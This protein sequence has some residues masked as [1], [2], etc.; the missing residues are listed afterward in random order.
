M[1]RKTLT[2]A[3]PLL[4]I[5][6]IPVLLRDTA[7]LNPSGTDQLVIVT[8]HNEAIR[9]EFERAF[10]RFAKTR[11]GRDIDI[12]WRTPG[13]TSEIVRY[14]RSAY[15]ANFRHWWTSQGKP[16][17]AT[18]Q[19]A[20]LDRKLT[21]AS[22][23][24]NAWAARQA[25][26][27]SDVSIGVDLLFGG[28]EFDARSLASEGILVPCGFRTRHPDLFTGDEPCLTR[29]VSGETWYD[30]DDRYY[31]TCLA[32]FG[33]CYNMD[34][35][36]EI[37]PG[38]ATPTQWNDLGEPWFLGQIGVADPSK[39]GSI[40]KCFE[41]LI[42]QQMARTARTCQAGTEAVPLGK[43]TEGLDRGW[44]NAM[45]LIRRISANAR[46]FTFAAGR[47]PVDV[48]QGD[49]AAG[50]C[51][52]FYGRAQAE[53]AQAETDRE[54]MRYITPPGGSSISADPIALFRG[55]PHAEA[56]KAFIDFVLSRE[57]QQ[58]WNYRPGTP[59]G[60][61][62]YALR[63]LPIRRDLYTPADKAN[64]SDPNAEPFVLAGQ[65][66]YQ[67]PWTGR[68]F[69]LIRVLIRVMAI[70]CHP[71]LRE[72]WQ[73]IIA[74]GGPERLPDAM[75]SLGKLPFAHHEAEAVAAE[76]RDPKK[77]ILLTRAWAEFFRAAYV[78]ARDLAANGPLTATQQ[79]DAATPDRRDQRL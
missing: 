78:D 37:H 33:I 26:L 19:A 44:H 59:G 3:A 20:F 46:Y 53:W 79:A 70:D 73:A 23:P 58:L 45:L 7:V 64:M 65:F 15:T 66:A 32:A 16:W 57:G 40:N 13:G 76:L 42:Q 30:T 52:D 35:L 22:A 61:E 63:R 34:R 36:N 27:Q 31:G 62:H 12:D 54:I 49:A 47:V 48:S 21:A 28:G 24:S 11:L 41:M 2:A 60:P 14:V 10:Q 43:D 25:F 17:G 6:L 68:L 74:N 9:Y 18:T 51:I 72:A 69:G 56:A 1:L 8:P 50:M 39:S 38:G 77:Q 29:Q 67:A 5:I 71:E 55:A 75:A 4:L